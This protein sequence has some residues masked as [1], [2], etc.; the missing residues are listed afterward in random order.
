MSIPSSKSRAILL[1]RLCRYLDTLYKGNQHYDLQKQDVSTLLASVGVSSDCADR[2]NSHAAFST[3]SFTRRVGLGANGLI[4]PM[5]VTI[6]KTTMHSM[7][8]V[9]PVTAS[10]LMT[11]RLCN[12]HSTLNHKSLILKYPSS[13][14]KK[15]NAVTSIPVSPT[16]GHQMPDVEPEFA[17][18]FSSIHNS[19]PSP[20]GS[21]TAIG[22]DSTSPQSSGMDD[23]GTTARASHAPHSHAL[24]CSHSWEWKMQ[25]RKQVCE[26]SQWYG[27]GEGGSCKKRD[28]QKGE[29]DSTGE[30]Q[31]LWQCKGCYIKVCPQHT[32]HL[33]PKGGWEFLEERRSG[34]TAQK[35]NDSRE[36]HQNKKLRRSE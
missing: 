22:G 19:P 17:E 34:K 21:D 27:P 35:W 33:H 4:P 5:A 10:Q 1:Q 24:E 23:I 7:G 6:A 18:T 15:G 31:R 29:W 30:A 9:P 8:L 25:R 26:F 2:S 36:A 20:S 32:N 28:A 13:S 11:T 3:M 16:F 12:R 14:L